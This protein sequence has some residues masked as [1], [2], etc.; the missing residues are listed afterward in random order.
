V[1]C[2]ETQGR[3]LEELSRRLQHDTVNFSLPRDRGVEISLQIAR[4]R[5]GLE[6]WIVDNADALNELLAFEVLLVPV[7]FLQLGRVSADEQGWKR[8]LR[9]PPTFGVLQLSRDAG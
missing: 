1:G 8:P 6:P 9:S 5:A 3:G 4:R 2:T 7:S